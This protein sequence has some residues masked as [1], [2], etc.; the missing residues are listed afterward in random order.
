MR[1]HGRSPDEAKACPPAPRR[2][3]PKFRR[4][5]AARLACLQR[6]RIVDRDPAGLITAV[7]FDP[8]PGA[9]AGRVELADGDGRTAWSNPIALG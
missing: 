8:P 2:R 3:R 5:P 1:D 6:A 7:K 9:A 4:R